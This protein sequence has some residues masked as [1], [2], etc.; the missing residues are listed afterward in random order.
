MRF[1]MLLLL[2][3]A[4]SVL[5]T[6]A[7]DD[8]TEDVPLVPFE[9]TTFGLQGIHPEGWQQVQPGTFVRGESQADLATLIIQQAPVPREQIEAIL[10]PQLLLDSFPEEADGQLETDAFTWDLYTIDVTAPGLE[11]RVSLALTEVD[12]ETYI[13]MLQALTD[14]HAALN[15]SVFLPAVEAV[16]PLDESPVEEV[17]YASEDV[18]FAQRRH[19]P[20][21]NPD[22]PRRRRPV[23]GSSDC[24]RQWT[25]PALRFT[26]AH[27]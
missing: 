25:H 21:R 20:G 22:H 16:A 10:L 13:V 12:G 23:P 27:R 17:A 19:H 15:E 24:L 18:T 5:P 9:S 3:M 8:S 2:A 4:G 14:E 6:I 1:L 11:V 7:Q 26:D